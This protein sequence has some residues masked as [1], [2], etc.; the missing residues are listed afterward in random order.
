MGPQEVCEGLPVLL[1]YPAVEGADEGVPHTHR[2]HSLPLPRGLRP[3]G[4]LAFGLA[5]DVASGSPLENPLGDLQYS[6]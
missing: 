4:F 2:P 3:L 5:L 1:D 6:P